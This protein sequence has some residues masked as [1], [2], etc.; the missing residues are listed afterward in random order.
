[1]PFSI[2]LRRLDPV[3]VLHHLDPAWGFRRAVSTGRGSMSGPPAS[4]IVA[5]LQ[6]PASVGILPDRDV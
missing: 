5:L 4:S 3:V 1:M 6:C 2:S